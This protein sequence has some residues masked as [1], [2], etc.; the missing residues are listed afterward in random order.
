MSKKTRGDGMMMNKEKLLVDYKSFIE[1]HLSSSSIISYLN[2]VKRYVEFIGD[3][4]LT[5]KTED[6]EAFLSEL[7]QLTKGNGE[8]KYKPASINRHR[9]SVVSLYNYLMSEC[10]VSHN[11]ASSVKGI[12]Y[13][14][15]RKDKIENYL[16][17]LEV[18]ELI[19]S[20]ES[21]PDISPF[22]KRRDVLMCNL[23]IWT[24]IKINELSRLKI[25]QFDVEQ[26]EIC[27]TDANGNSRYLPLTNTLVKNFNS[28]MELREKLAS[29]IG[30]DYLFLSERKA[31]L[32]LQLTNYTLNKHRNNAGLEK[33]VN[34]TTLRNTFVM[35]MFENGM[36]V[37]ELSKLLGHSAINFT[38]TFYAEYVSRQQD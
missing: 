28:Y 19:S 5:A 27:V 21:N 7:S 18:A 22:I 26:M 24:G 17:P 15:C 30:E 35:K 34:N 36:A 23:M 20:I 1:P 29:A 32:S 2:D 38:S 13:K 25:N 12:H 8:L 9:A 16:T 14:E 3:N 37:E 31:P 11:P 6:V 33:K 10:L 4:L